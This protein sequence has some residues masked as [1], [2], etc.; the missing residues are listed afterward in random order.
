MTLFISDCESN[1]D[2]KKHTA[3]SGLKCAVPGNKIIHTY[4]QRINGNYKGVFGGGGGCCQRKSFK[5]KAWSFLN[6][7]CNLG[8]CN[9]FV[10]YLRI[11]PSGEIVIKVIVLY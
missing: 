1:E 9:S 7:A 6:N 8:N 5:R 10:N 3:I 2:M 4:P 11:A